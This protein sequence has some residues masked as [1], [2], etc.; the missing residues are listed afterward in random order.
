MFW[1]C[2]KRDEFPVLRPCVLD[3]AALCARYL[4]ARGKR[5]AENGAAKRLISLAGLKRLVCPCSIR[6]SAGEISKIRVLIAIT[7]GLMPTAY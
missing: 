1:E 5:G 4:I 3:A 7:L 2:T 6:Q